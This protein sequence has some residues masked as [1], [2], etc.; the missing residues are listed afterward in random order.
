MTAAEKTASLLWKSVTDQTGLLI[1]DVPDNEAGVTGANLVTNGCFEDGLT[2][3]SAAS[4]STLS[5]DTGT[6]VCGTQSMNMDVPSGDSSGG[7]D[8]NVVMSSGVPHVVNFWTKGD[9]IAEYVQL[10]GG[11]FTSDQIM[12]TTEWKKHSVTMTRSSDGSVQFLG[13]YPAADSAFEWWIDGVTARPVETVPLT[14]KSLRAVTRENQIKYPRDIS[15]TSVWTYSSGSSA[16]GIDGYLADTVSGTQGI[17]Q[18]LTMTAGTKGVRYTLEKGAADWITVAFGT[19]STKE[20]SFNLTTLK[21][22]SAGTLPKLYYIGTNTKGQ[23][24]IDVSDDMTAGAQSFKIYMAT[25]DGA[26]TAYS[27]DGSTVDLYIKDT[28]VYDGEPQNNIGTADGGASA[29]PRQLTVEVAVDKQAKWDDRLVQRADATSDA[30]GWMLVDDVNNEPMDD[31]AGNVAV[32]R[33]AGLYKAVLTGAWGPMVEGVAYYT[34][35]DTGNFVEKFT[36]FGTLAATTSITTQLT[37]PG[38]YTN[39]SIIPVLVT[40]H[41]DALTQTGKICNIGSY[42]SPTVFA[43][44]DVTTGLGDDNSVV[45]TVGADMPSNDARY[46]FI[47]EYKFGSKYY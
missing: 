39:P 33:R 40:G 27:G 13:F 17:H 10:F 43:A 12:L 6:K 11:G 24:Q 41:V 29:F 47:M 9:G 23:I 30:D 7:S 3:W 15:Q 44:V 1:Q 22:G 32:L 8:P 16:V 5:L 20:V 4:G 21:A 45:L 26:Y 19:A 31:S 14:D 36:F 35:D 42:Q 25:G 37:A 34:N 28:Q 46:E 2:G 18:S 38:T